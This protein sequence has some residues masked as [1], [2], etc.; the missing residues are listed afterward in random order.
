MENLGR[1]ILP[2][3]FNNVMIKYY[4]NDNVQGINT[5]EI[6]NDYIGGTEGVEYVAKHIEYDRKNKIWSLAFKLSHGNY[7]KITWD[8]NGNYLKIRS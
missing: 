7:L 8:E 6:I 1:Y 2:Q 4:S 3:I 5:R